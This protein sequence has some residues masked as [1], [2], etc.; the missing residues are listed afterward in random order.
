[1]TAVLDRFGTDVK[2]YPDGENHFTVTVQVK[3][4]QPFFGWLFGFGD[5]VQI[6]EP[7]EVRLE[8]AERLRKVLKSA[9]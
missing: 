2:L 6:L 3:A 7:E 9:E 1:M 8:Y 4:E 5:A